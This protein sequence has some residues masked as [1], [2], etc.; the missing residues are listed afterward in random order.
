MTT[1]ADICRRVRQLEA[2]GGDRLIILNMG[3]GRDSITMLSLLAEGPIRAQ[4]RDIYAD[5]VDAV[6][7]AD[8]G[9][10]WKHTYATIPQVEQLSGELGIPFLWLQKPK[11]CEWEPYEEGLK[12]LRGTGKKIDPKVHES[13]RP[14]RRA[15]ANMTIMEKAR[16]G[17]YHYR[18]PIIEDYA[19]RE[20][21]VRRKKA[22]CTT[23]HKVDVIRRAMADLAHE[24]YGVKSN[25]AWGRKVKAGEAAPHLNLVGIAKDE[26]TRAIHRH[27]CRVTGLKPGVWYADEAYPLLEMGITKADEQ[28]ILE[29]HEF[30]HVRKSGCVMCPYQPISWYWMLREVEPEGWTRTV[31]YEGAAVK[32]GGWTIFTHA[33]AKG[34]TKEQRLMY[35]PEAVERWRGRNPDV[36]IDEVLRKAY[37]RGHACTTCVSG[38]DVYE[39]VLETMDP[40]IAKWME[41]NRDKVFDLIAEEQ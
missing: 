10:E 2:E 30:G 39:R 25:A 40:T 9:A 8:T 14:W 26:A 18:A 15:G 23:N 24:K 29:R 13:L 12:P 28:P 19:G 21:T 6:I 16:T 22:D 4:G 11:T 5:D 20:T 34:R 35:L 17:W 38:E 32:A 27:P 37:S 3:L 7:F 31:D 1:H 36:T 41:A 33:K